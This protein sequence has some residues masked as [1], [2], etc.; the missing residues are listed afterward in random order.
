M[1]VFFTSSADFLGRAPGL[2]WPVAR[3]FAPAGVRDAG[4]ADGASAVLA[5]GLAWLLVLAV[6]AA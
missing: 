5:V 4:D 1:L 3:S 2:A 6:R